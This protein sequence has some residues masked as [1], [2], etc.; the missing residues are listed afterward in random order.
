MFDPP[1]GP[2]FKLNRVVLSKRTSVFITHPTNPL[3]DGWEE[4]SPEVIAWIPEYEP[5]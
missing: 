5:V 3:M 1:Q 2:R 4:T